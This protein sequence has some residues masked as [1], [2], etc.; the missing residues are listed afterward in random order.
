MAQIRRSPGVES[1]ATSNTPPSVQA[2]YSAG[3]DT[4]RAALLRMRR[5][6]LRTVTEPCGCRWACRCPKP[7]T[8]NQ[9]DA[10]FKAAAYLL[11]QGVVPQLPVEVLRA[12]WLRG[13]SDRELAG[14]LYA[15]TWAVVT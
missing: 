11:D 15:A 12:L 14:E 8:V 10:W 4:A 5:I 9:I 1:R 13:G 6:M 3:N 2:Q 7:L